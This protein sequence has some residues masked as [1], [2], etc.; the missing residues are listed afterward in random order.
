MIWR[1]DTSWSAAIHNQNFDISIYKSF[2]SRLVQLTSFSA[3]KNMEHWRW[4][5]SKVLV[6]LPL[7]PFPGSVVVGLDEAGKRVKHLSG[8]FTCIFSR[9]T[10]MFLT[11]VSFI[12]YICIIIYTKTLACFSPLTTDCYYSENFVCRFLFSRRSVSWIV[13]VADGG[14]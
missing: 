4:W 13:F 3:F 8:I 6:K 11:L 9:S 10:Y 2:R 5:S 14:G 12:E 1:I 7:S